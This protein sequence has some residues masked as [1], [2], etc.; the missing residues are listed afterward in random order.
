MSLISK[1]TASPNRV[2]MLVDFLKTNS[3]KF[4]KKDL[5]LMF[6]P[7]SGSVFKEVYSVVEMFNLLVMR[8]DI[9]YHNIENKK[10]KNNE[11]IKKSLFNSEDIQNYNFNLSLTWL[12]VQ[13]PKE[14]I[15][16]K[17]NVGNKFIR[18]LTEQVLE[19]ELTNN[20]R[21]QHFIYWCE[22]L[23]FVNKISISGETFICPD[24]TQ[25]IKDELEISFK[26]GGRYSVKD[27]FIKLSTSIPVL[28]YGVIREKVNSML[29]DGLSLASDTLSYST[30]LAIIR[31]EQ[32]KI[33]SFE[34]K[35]DA[36]IVT[37]LDGTINHRISHIKYLGQ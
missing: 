6:S 3:K 14:L 15:N 31:L 8:E 10:K 16:F 2:E 4:T 30:S 27:F 20:A 29:R 33:I 32:E 1:L 23:G 7:D 19:T 13:N 25:V 22:Y 12:L 34:S 28:E 5:E 18:D 37:L 11:I 26:K 17:D 24:P 36:E 21:F 35:S 9:V